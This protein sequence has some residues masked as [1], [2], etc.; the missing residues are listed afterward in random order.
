MFVLVAE[1]GSVK[2]VHSA[3]KMYIRVPYGCRNKQLFF[4]AQLTSAWMTVCGQLHASAAF[5][6]YHWRGEW[7]VP[8]WVSTRYRT[9]NSNQWQQSSCHGTE[10]AIPVLV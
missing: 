10:L 6:L 3:L 1:G 8:A 2:T 7:R 9:Q 4:H 5:N